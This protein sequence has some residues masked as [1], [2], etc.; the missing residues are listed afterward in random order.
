[1]AQ[2]IAQPSYC[3]DEVAETRAGCGIVDVVKEV[4]ETLFAI[5]VFV[6]AR[7]QK[8]VFGEKRSALIATVLTR[9]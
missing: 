3:G 7:L 6:A 5:S 2:R 8:P 4:A 9:R 1:M